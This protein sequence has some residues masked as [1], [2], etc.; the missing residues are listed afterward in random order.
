MSDYV[1]RHATVTDRPGL[2]GVFTPEMQ[3]MSLTTDGEGRVEIRGFDGLVYWTSEVYPAA[4]YSPSAD[5]WDA[6]QAE[7]EVTLRRALVEWA[8][9]QI[10]S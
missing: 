9:M 5:A 7:W 6:A 10:W 8:E 2:A 4:D 3:V 1:P